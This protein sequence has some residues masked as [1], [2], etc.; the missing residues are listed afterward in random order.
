MRPLLVS[1]RRLPFGDFTAEDFLNGD[2]VILRG[3]R[4]VSLCSGSGL[5]LGQMADA[6]V[7]FGR[8]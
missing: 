3:G 6:C 4:F 2:V 5:T 8:S 1:L 7:Y